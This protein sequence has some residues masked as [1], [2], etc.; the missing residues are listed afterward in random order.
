MLG[1]N[2]MTKELMLGVIIIT[3]TWV[4]G[5]LSTPRSEKVAQY[6]LKLVELRRLTFAE[7]NQTVCSFHHAENMGRLMDRASFDPLGRYLDTL[8]DLSKGLNGC[9]I[10]VLLQAWT[11]I[12]QLLLLVP[13]DDARQQEEY[14]QHERRVVINEPFF[15]FDDDEADCTA[16]C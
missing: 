2:L 9:D 15:P 4:Q 14:Q 8:P 10:C 1:W 12:N 11:K 3:G 7:L 13:A 16:S 5:C 6:G